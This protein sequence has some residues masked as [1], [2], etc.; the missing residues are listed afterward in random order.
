MNAPETDKKLRAIRTIVAEIATHLNVPLSLKIWDGEY[1][2]L[3][4]DAPNQ[5]ALVI[6]EP[7]V[8][9]A[10]IRRPTLDRLLR[11]YAHGKVGFEGGTLIDIA[12]AAGQTS[13]RGRLKQI[14]K[15]KLARALLPFVMAPASNV[16]PSRSFSGDE[17]GASKE[18]R[19]EGDFISFH[20]D[21]SND[22]YK[23]FLDDAMVYTCAYFAEW[24]NDLDRAQFD[25]MEMTCRKLR[26]KAGDRFLDIGCG[27]GALICHAAKHYGA[28]AH[29]VTLSK[30]QYDYAVERIKR[31]GLGDRVTIELNDYRDVD[32]K[33]D[34]IASIGMYE[35]IGVAAVPEYLRKVRSMLAPGGLF[36][37]HG[38]T[39][40]SK[41]KKKRFG[42]RPE[43]RAL[44][45]YI[46]PG[47]ELD[48]IG[49][50]AQELE[51]AGF[52]IH[53]IE[54]WREHY[55][56]TTRM[57]CERL[58]AR[59]EEA[60]ALVGEQAYRIWVVYLAG[61]S[62]AFTRGSARIYQTLASATVKGPAPV[63]PSRADLYR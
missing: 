30:E 50:T 39:R 56:L 48:D 60:V 6:S 4:T 14:S 9:S 7:G 43:Q 19:N 23:L 26:I 10:L 5:P 54:G 33:F 1:L 40:R 31:E 3:G 12:E 41:R 36:L 58:T 37:N 17:I 42:K 13:T 47:G 21:L 57:W 53:D 20:Y 24:Q 25:K 28:T 49:H 16:I 52:E 63:P 22:F 62:I 59:R 32:Q 2:P 11:L 45:R 44:V 15:R 29:G 8:I 27:W 18:S 34:K 35:A 46:F 55:A 61:C 38:I 51:R